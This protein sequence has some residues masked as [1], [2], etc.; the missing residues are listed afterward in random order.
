MRRTRR[1]TAIIGGSGLQTLPGFQVAEP[2]APNTPWGPTSGPV[3]RGTLAGVES[4]FLPRHGGA[5]AIPPH[6]VNYRANI[7]ALAAQGV[8]RILAFNAVGGIGAS[9]PPGLLVV[10]HQLIDYTWGRPS[11][12]W[13]GPDQQPLHIDF[14]IPYDSATRIN[15]IEAAEAEGI[16]VRPWGVYGATQGPR[17]ETA[18]E[19]R[20]L[21]RDGCDL[22]GMTGMPEAALARE[23][24]IAYACLALVVNPAAGTVPGVIELQD[25][26]RV[27]DAAIPGAVRLL[28]RALTEAD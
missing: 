7:A 23:K 17:L 12:Y 24:G 19:I 10:P 14:T 13:D 9:F 16:P 6:L 1:I 25:I 2:M 27:M 20:R 28:V 5:R 4:Y 21:R 22:V 15:L 18:A 26:Q 3:L 11:S 8:E